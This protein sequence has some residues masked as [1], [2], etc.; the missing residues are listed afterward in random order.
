MQIPIIPL[1]ASTHHPARNKFTVSEYTFSIFFGHIFDSVKHFVTLFTLLFQST[2][3]I[4]QWGLSA[5]LETRSETLVEESYSLRL[6]RVFSAPTSGGGGGFYVSGRMH[7][8]YAN[9]EVPDELAAVNP[10]YIV[11]EGGGAL[12]LS[13]QFSIFRPFIGYSYNYEQIEWDEGQGSSLRNPLPEQ[14]YFGHGL[15]YGARAKLSIFTF[16]WETRQLT[17]LGVE[18][19]FDFSGSALSPNRSMIGVG[20]GF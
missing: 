12:L 6:E 7:F 14:A 15:V 18:D 13:L 5:G 1:Y 8:G 9:V 3:A 4:A 10:N 17:Y 16:F 19:D 20:F 11:M 2:L